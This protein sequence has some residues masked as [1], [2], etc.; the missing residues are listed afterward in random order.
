LR[1]D[2]LLECS[3]CGFDFA[4]VGEAPDGELGEDLGAV[5]DHVVDPARALDQARRDAQLAL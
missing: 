5:H 2:A 3:N 1:D 4:R